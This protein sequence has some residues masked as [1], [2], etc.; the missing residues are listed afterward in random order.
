[1]CDIGKKRDL[2]KRK[3]L[4]FMRHSDQLRFLFRNLLIL[5]GQ[6]LVLA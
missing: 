2:I 6:H 3:L 4:Y 5:L 1:M